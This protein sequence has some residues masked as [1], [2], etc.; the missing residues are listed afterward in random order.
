V[1][2]NLG[3]RST[4]WLHDAG[5]DSLEQLRK[6]GPELA[7]WKVR[8]LGHPATK[9]L[10]WGLVAACLDKD[11]RELTAAEKHHALARVAALSDTANS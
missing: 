7:Y 6:L 5:I 3:P 2:R 11:W 1:I 9:N 10:L 4:S 8:A